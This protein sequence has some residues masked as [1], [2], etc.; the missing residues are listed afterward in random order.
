[1]PVQIFSWG[2]WGWGTATR[3]LR[4]AIDAVEDQRG[5]ASPTFVDIRFRRAGRAPGFRGDAFEKLL[6]RRR[7][8]WMPTLGN[9]NVSTGRRARIACPAAVHHL[10]DLALDNRDRDARVIFFCACES[11]EAWWCHRHMVSRLLRRAARDRRIS[12]NVAEWPGGRPS[13]QVLDLPVSR[14]TLQKVE[15]GLQAIPLSRKPM[16]YAFLGVPWGTVIMLSDGRNE[17]PVAIGP[18]AYRSG[19]WILPR[20]GSAQWSAEGVRALRRRTAV[21]RKELGL[22]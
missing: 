4:S 3:Q 10:L 22:H 9:A 17:L 15:Q 14:E 20:F 21:L 2:F 6:G 12:I 11:P 1:M 13:A 5:F 7:Y 8:R 18:A 16:P 19:W